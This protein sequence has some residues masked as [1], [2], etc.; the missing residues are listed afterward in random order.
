MYIILYYLNMEKY[1]NKLL[2]MLNYLDNRLQ[3]G[4]AGD[5]AISI[6]KLSYSI[7]H[8]SYLVHI[9]KS[10]ETTKEEKIISESTNIETHTKEQQLRLGCDKEG[11]LYKTSMVLTFKKK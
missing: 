1:G 4:G 10:T 8:V 5:N 9:G 11:Y 3:I 2:K 7:N 6:E